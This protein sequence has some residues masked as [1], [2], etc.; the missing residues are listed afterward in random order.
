MPFDELATPADLATRLVGAVENLSP[1]SVIAD[2]AAGDGALLLAAR[3]RWQ[4]ARLIATDIRPSAITELRA[5]FPR[6]HVGRCDFLNRRSRDAC[7]PLRL[8]RQTGVNLVLLN[9]PFSCRGGSR[10]PIVFER[11]SLF[12]SR[13]LAF[14]AAAIPYLA[15]EGTLV[16]ILPSSIVSAQRDRAAWDRLKLAGAE[17]VM[18]FDRNTFKGAS[19]GGVVLRLRRRHSKFGSA[20]KRTL[21]TD[22]LTPS[23]SFSQK[24]PIEVFRGKLPRYKA[25]KSLCPTGY[26]YVHTTDVGSRGWITS[27]GQRRPG[28]RILRVNGSERSVVSG[29]LVLLPRVGTPKSQRPTLYLPRDRILLSDCL[30]ALKCVSRAETVACHSKLTLMWRFIE[31]FYFGSAAKYL[32]IEHLLVALSSIGFEPRMMVS[33][34][35]G[36][37][38][39]ERELAD[40]V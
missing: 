4:E 3:T 34:A 17:I 35:L 39:L 13:A 26:P 22:P 30:F 32:T 9:P 11:E 23:T 20:R 37:S 18:E 36:S 6:A 24:T 7:R 19:V 5:R 33:R 10:L 12:S 31:R 25:L 2:F 14:V 16:A 21:Q 38:A 15:A 1:R 29:P 28:G 8:A 27:K 40:A